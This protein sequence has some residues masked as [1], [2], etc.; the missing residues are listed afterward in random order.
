MKTA[1]A[2]KPKTSILGRP[3]KTSFQRP[4]DLAPAGAGTLDRV[5]VR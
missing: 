5:A 1:A 2:Y 4:I 3:D